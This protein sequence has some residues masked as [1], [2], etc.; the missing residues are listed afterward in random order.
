MVKSEWALE[1][2]EPALRA[3]C[4]RAACR[5]TDRLLGLRGDRVLYVGDHIYG[6]MVSMRAFAGKRR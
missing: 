2:H 5:R 6:D 1:G 4:V 3:G